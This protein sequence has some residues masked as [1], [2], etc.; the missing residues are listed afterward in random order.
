MN[1]PLAAVLIL[2][3][4]LIGSVP[5]AFLLG[6]LL[7]GIDIRQYGSGNVGATNVLRTLGWGPS[8]V[9][10]L[11]DL[12]KAALPTWVS[13]QISGSLL[14]AALAALAAVCGHNWPIFLRFAGGKGVTSSL[15]ALLVLLP[16]VGLFVGL[17]GVAVIAVTRYVS[18]GSL[19]GAVLAPP[20]AL[21]WY[22]FGG[23]GEPLLYC[24]VI[25]PMGIYRHRANIRRLL[26]GTENKLGQRVA[27]R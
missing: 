16:V 12:F 22:A 23:P 11:L 14:V 6:K 27:V 10:F 19:V 3:S 13:W 17:I 20:A 25:S 4:Y 24:L 8:L 1:L 26:A 21:V 2:A 9:V 18:L 15:G 5:P 7:G